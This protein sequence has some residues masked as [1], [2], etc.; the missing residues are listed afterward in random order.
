VKCELMNVG[1]YVNEGKLRNDID[2]L[3]NIMNVC[4]FEVKCCC[5]N[6]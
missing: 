5:V 3:D 6:C 4:V 1:Y 2:I